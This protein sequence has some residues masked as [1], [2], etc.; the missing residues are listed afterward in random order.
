M[1]LPCLAYILACRLTNDMTRIDSARARRRNSAVLRRKQCRGPNHYN[2]ANR[3]YPLSSGAVPS[4]AFRRAAGSPTNVTYS[5]LA[6]SDAGRSARRSAVIHRRLREEA[7]RSSHSATA[8]ANPSRWVLLQKPT[9]WPLQSVTDWD[10]PACRSR[11]R[12]RRWPPPPAPARS[13][14]GSWAARR[15]QAVR[16][17]DPHACR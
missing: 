6:F 11:D 9:C 14:A 8:A 15:V 7:S 4:T 2:R 12:A 13:P 10:R 3:P 16:H 5:V 1:K 17:R